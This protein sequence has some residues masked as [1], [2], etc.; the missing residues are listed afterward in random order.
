MNF[1]KDQITKLLFQ[2]NFALEN[3][4]NGPD[5][6]AA[7]APFRYDKDRLEEGM[8]IRK[9]AEACHR[10][11]EKKW[12]K[13]QGNSVRFKKIWD[14]VKERYNTDVQLARIAF[15]K[16][17]GTLDI[18]QVRGTRKAAVS[19]WLKQAKV[20]YMNSFKSEEIMA[21]LDYLGLTREKLEEGQAAIEKF[22]K[23]VA[24]KEDIKG[25][26]ISAT[27]ERNEALEEL[28]SWFSDFRAVIFL[29]AKGDQFPERMGW[30]V[31]SGEPPQNDIISEDEQ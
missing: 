10:N 22:E 12:N 19:E 16:D 27:K 4:L 8:R 18:L 23:A 21:G 26:A 24:E 15:K 5:I 29:A 28:R 20:F 6:M 14:E 2:S 17:K 7:I 3:A 1:T 31:R 11:R 9:K 30:L 13:V 25:Q